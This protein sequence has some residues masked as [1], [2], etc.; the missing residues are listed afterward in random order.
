MLMCRILEYLDIKAQKILNKI[1]EIRHSKRSAQFLL[2]SI[3]EINF[4]IA[5]NDTGG[6]ASIVSI[7]V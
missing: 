6:T 4:Y 7:I 2:D 3:I 1:V 5:S